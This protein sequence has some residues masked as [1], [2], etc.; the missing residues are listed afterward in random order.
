MYQF[1]TGEGA[2]GMVCKGTVNGPKGM[3]VRV[4]IKQLKTNAADEERREFHREIEMMKKVIR[5]L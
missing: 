2:F 4:A 3:P 5:I 1:I